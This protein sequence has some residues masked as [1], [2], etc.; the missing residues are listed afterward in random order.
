MTV[1][2]FSV[3][4]LYRLLSTDTASMVHLIYTELGVYYS[5]RLIFIRFLQNFLRVLWLNP[6]LHVILIK[7]TR[8]YHLHDSVYF[9]IFVLS[10]AKQ[11]EKIQCAFQVAWKRSFCHLFL[12]AVVLFCPLFL[13]YWTK[14]SYFNHF[15]E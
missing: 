12:R 10:R 11:N 7:F 13:G 5:R 3:G 14:S 4:F 15:V 9:V 6:E 2:F 8:L 1:H